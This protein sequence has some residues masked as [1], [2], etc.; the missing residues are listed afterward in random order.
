V[1]FCWKTRKFAEGESA[2]G[3]IGHVRPPWV[4]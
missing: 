1:Q 4:G 3:V 2:S